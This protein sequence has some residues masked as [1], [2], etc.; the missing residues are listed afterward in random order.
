MTGYGDAAG[1]PGG[2]GT[3]AWARGGAELCCEPWWPAPGARGFLPVGDIPEA[4]QSAV[5]RWLRA[6][7]PDAG[8]REVCGPEVRGCRC[9]GGSR[10]RSWEVERCPPPAVLWGT[11]WEPPGTGA[12][13]CVGGGISVPR[14]GRCPRRGWATGSRFSGVGL[15]RAWL[16]SCSVLR[17]GHPVPRLRTRSTASPQGRGGSVSTPRPRHPWCLLMPCPAVLLSC[18]PSPPQ[19]AAW[20]PLNSSRRAVHE[21]C[22]VIE[23]RQGDGRES[24]QFSCHE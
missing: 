16:W 3:V 20:P 22:R 21:G 19:V 7:S 18:C 15:G 6:E 23:P 24:R 14:A 17:R 13:V 9:R 12:P 8:I 1:G 10:G 11:G 4:R 5:L 2:A